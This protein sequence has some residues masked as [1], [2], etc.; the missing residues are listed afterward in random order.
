MQNTFSS[1]PVVKK[2]KDYITKLNEEN[3]DYW[4]EQDSVNALRANWKNANSKYDNGIYT[5]AEQFAKSAKKNA[6]S[7]LEEGAIETTDTSGE[8]LTNIIIILIVI[9][10]GVFLFEKFYLNKKKEGETSEYEENY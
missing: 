9:I 6:I 2:T 4:V 10:V 1:T 8:F 3:V 5:S 7:I